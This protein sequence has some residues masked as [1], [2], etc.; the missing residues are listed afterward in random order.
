[1]DHLY[2]GLSAQPGQFQVQPAPHPGAVQSRAGLRAG[3]SASPCQNAC[4]GVR[5]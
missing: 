3:P 4:I 2:A 5:A 1:M